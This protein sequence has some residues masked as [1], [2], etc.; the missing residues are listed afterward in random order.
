MTAAV[1]QKTISKKGALSG[2][3]LHTGKPSRIAFSPAPPQSGVRWSQ[4]GR[5]IVSTTPTSARRCTGIGNLQTVEHVLAALQGLGIDNV[6][7]DV[8]GPEVP[9]MD[10]S[11]APFVRC[12]K[13]LGLVEQPAPRNYYR[14]KEPVF[15]GDKNKA[16]CAFPAE[17]FSVAYV[18]D[19]DH[20]RL[21]SQIASF[22]SVTAEIFEKEIAPSRTFCTSQEA[23]LLRQQGFGLGATEENTIVISENGKLQLRFDDECARHK[24]LDL[25]GDLGLLGFPILARVIGIRSGHALNHR[26]VELIRKQKEG[27]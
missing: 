2:V 14:L 9:A 25:I 20:P 10:G 1:L 27:L 7:V 5:P 6:G 22:S 21:R 3:G 12:L 18:L 17:A 19:Y 23:D 8:E 15:C 13:E 26:L 24:A 11:A 4:D 16:I